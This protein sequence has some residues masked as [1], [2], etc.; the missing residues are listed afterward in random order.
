MTLSRK[1]GSRFRASDDDF[2]TF[3]G[4]TGRSGRDR[5]SLPQHGDE[6]SAKA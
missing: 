4:N 5:Q 1:S 6:L 2:T 3:G